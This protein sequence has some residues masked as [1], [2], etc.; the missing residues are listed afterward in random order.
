MSEPRKILKLTN[1]YAAG[2]QARAAGLS[3][4]ERAH[5]A[6]TILSSISESH[7]LWELI[8]ILLGAQI[9]QEHLAS[10]Q[11]DLS[12]EQLRTNV[13]RE[14]SLEDFRAMILDAWVRAR[15]GRKG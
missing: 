14:A 5:E 3:F 7:P 12:S 1:A 10:R 4:D 13:A 6:A 9:I 2:W 11:P 8:Q 15:E